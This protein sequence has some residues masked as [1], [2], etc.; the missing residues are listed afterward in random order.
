M[1]TNRLA[2]RLTSQVLSEQ[3]GVK[4]DMDKA[5]LDFLAKNPMPSDDD[6]HAFAEEQGFDKHEAEVVAYKFATAFSLFMTGGKA[7]EKGLAPD[8][9]DQ[10]QVRMGIEVELEH[11]PCRDMAER[12]V[13]D[14]LA[15]IPDY[16]TRLKKME[17]EA[18]IKE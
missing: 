15:E 6:M 13:M 16:Y 14:H 11:V 4:T 8:D 5:V 18:G 17:A 1:N 9:V 2:A 7:N 3:L 12:I 10:E